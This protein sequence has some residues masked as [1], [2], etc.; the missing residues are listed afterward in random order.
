MKRMHI[1]VAVER[2]DQSIKFYNALFNTEPV[3]TKTDYAR[4]MLDDPRV[5]FAISTHC[6]KAGFDHMGLQVDEDS[7]LEEMREGLR[8]ADMTLSDEG[9]T[10]CCY[11]RSNKSWVQDPTGIPWE[12]YRT[13]ENV[14]TFSGSGLN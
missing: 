1:H 7:E 5:N 10:V 11:S 14:E 13:M 3:V 9:E 8:N 2:L 6:G 12:V 4:W